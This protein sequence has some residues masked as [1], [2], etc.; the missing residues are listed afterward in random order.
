MSDD[1]L[2]ERARFKSRDRLCFYLSILAGRRVISKES[3]S[4][5]KCYVLFLPL[6][7]F[8][9]FKHCEYINCIVPINQRKE[10]KNPK[11]KPGKAQIKKKLPSMLFNLQPHV[12]H[13]IGFQCP[14]RGF[15]SRINRFQVGCSGLL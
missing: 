9:S 2:A 15:N 5:K 7:C 8:L 11:K 13:L 14:Q 3:S 4:I 6:S 10:N 12:W 1:I